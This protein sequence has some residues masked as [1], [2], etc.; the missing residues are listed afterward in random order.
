MDLTQIISRVAN[1]DSCTTSFLMEKQFRSV[2]YEF[3]WLLLIA[4]LVQFVT[5]L[6]QT[7]YLHPDQHFQ[8]I[9]FSS[10]QLG[11]PSGATRVWEL[12]SHIRPTVQVYL[13]SGFVE[14][15]RL[16]HIYDPYVQL[17]ILRV[18]MGLAGFVLFN[19]MAISYFRSDRRVLYL[20]LL[21]LN[22][23]WLLP[24]TRAMFSSEMASSLA[25]F[26]AV[27]LY[28][29]R[30]NSFFYVLLMGLLFSLAFYFR[31]Q[32][33]F[34][35]A[36]FGL[37][38]LAIEKKYRNLLPLTIGFG[39]GLIINILLDYQFYHELVFTPYDYFRVNITEGKAAE[40]GTSGPLYYV[41]M[42]F[43]VVGAPTL[44][45]FLIY[46]A[47]KQTRSAYR[48]PLFFAVLFFIIGHSFV[49]HKE[50]RFL[51]P[52]LNVLPM[53][54]GW[55][56]S[57]FIRYYRQT[58]R[59]VRQFITGNLYLSLALNTLALL[60]FTLVPISQTVEFSEKITNRFGQSDTT[61]YYLARTPF[62][63]QG[64]LPLTFYRRHY[65]N[66]KLVGVQQADSV[67]Y[68][69]NAWLVTTYNDAKDS[70]IALDS[71]G[72]TPQFYSS[73]LIWNVNRLLESRGINTI[74]D[75][76]VLYRKE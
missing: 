55:G 22:F 12:T 62:E 54:A 34:G 53:V 68:L 44:S 29:R 46:Y 67:Q 74:N 61:I 10:W 57:S 26:A 39:I 35:L 3:R 17:T 27:L 6:T 49:G 7:G 65:P 76:W 20:V 50:E 28:E 33:A 15:C 41:V 25:F 19:A 56:L 60:V 24:Y 14:M 5:C 64:G 42:L 8:L 72:Y 37:W 2:L 66:L 73:S 43:L 16:L 38:L 11:E 48:Q 58:S 1:G 69:K 45:F 52:I 21:L 75:I 23:S 51:F 71:L 63:T 18:L 13:F 40:F 9:E 32:M 4:L 31:F 70:H 30:G 47:A 59:A 36:G